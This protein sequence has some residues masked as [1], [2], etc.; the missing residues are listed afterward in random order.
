MFIIQIVKEGRS[1][2]RRGKGSMACHCALEMNSE[3]RS[4]AGRAAVRVTEALVVETVKRLSR[5]CPPRSSQRLR[6][7]V[8]H[9]PP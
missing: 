3:V 2:E 1:A 5:G 9:P 8:Q 6:E 4:E 7:R